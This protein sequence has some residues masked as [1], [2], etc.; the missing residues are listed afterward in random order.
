[1]ATFPTAFGSFAAMRRPREVDFLAG[2]LQEVQVSV[3]CANDKGLTINPEKGPWPGLSI[4]RMTRF[5]LATLT[6][7]R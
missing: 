5:E 1:V 4:E 3:A 7:A 2:R 6:L